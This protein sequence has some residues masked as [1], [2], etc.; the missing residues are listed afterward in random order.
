MAMTDYEKKVAAM[1]A[2]TAIQMGQMPK[3]NSR[4]GTTPAQ[5]EAFLQGFGITQQDLDTFQKNWSE[6]DAKN[7]DPRMTPSGLGLKGKS[8]ATSFSDTAS[9]PVEYMRSLQKSFSAPT[10]GG[11][12]PTPTTPTPTPPIASSGVQGFG[13]SNRP[14]APGVQSRA[15]ASADLQNSYNAFSAKGG[16]VEGERRGEQVFRPNSARQS[17][18][19]NLNEMYAKGQVPVVGNGMDSAQVVTG[20]QVNDYYKNQD[21]RFKQTYATIASAGAK[22]QYEENLAMADKRNADVKAMRDNLSAGRTKVTKTKAERLAEIKGASEEAVSKRD[23]VAENTSKADISKAFAIANRDDPK[24]AAAANAVA[25]SREAIVQGDYK[26]GAASI[27][28]AIQ[29][30]I[31][32]MGDGYESKITQEEINSVLDHPEI[33]PEVI[34]LMLDGAEE[35][36]KKNEQF[37]FVGYMI[38]AK[39]LSLSRLTGKSGK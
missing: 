28:S 39:Q 23:K 33:G 31:A 16:M 14:Q 20:Q 37:D 30:Q 27:K 11:P 17:A 32:S 34:G 7:P 26:V 3:A 13:V 4:T 18:A 5:K 38:M 22:Q 10:G 24:L 25:K 35:A 6:F 19:A 15:N 12:Q 29:S 21:E 1:K 2:W 8:G 9:S 36:M